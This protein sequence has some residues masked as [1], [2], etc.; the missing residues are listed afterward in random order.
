M[1]AWQLALRAGRLES[2]RMA[3]YTRPRVL[4]LLLLVLQLTCGERDR[5]VSVAFEPRPCEPVPLEECCAA[6][7]AGDAVPARLDRRMISEDS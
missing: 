1:L 2:M 4:G 3:G 6:Y 7:C 5:T